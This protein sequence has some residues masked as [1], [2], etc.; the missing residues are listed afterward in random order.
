MNYH[1]NNLIETDWISHTVSLFLSPSTRETLSIVVSRSALFTRGGGG[2]MGML[3]G[4]IPPSVQHRRWRWS[5]A[6]LVISQW[7]YFPLERICEHVY[8]L[9]DSGTV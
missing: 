8:G 6:M 1:R 9:A 4:D 7:V 3:M 5:F 2:F